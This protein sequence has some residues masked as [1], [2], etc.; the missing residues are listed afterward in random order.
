MKNNSFI[1]L[2]CILGI[3]L[4]SIMSYSVLKNLKEYERVQSIDVNSVKYEKLDELKKKILN[5]PY[6]KESKIEL[7]EERE[8]LTIDKS[9]ELTIKSNRYVMNIKDSK[10][11]NKYCELVDA[12]E[13]SLG[14]EVGKSLNTCKEALKGVIS[15]FGLNVD[16]GSDF[17]T[18]NLNNE[19]PI[20]L[21]DDTNS[22]KEK[23]LISIEEV[24]YNIKIDDYIFTSLSVNLDDKKLNV[25]SNIFN[26]KNKKEKTFVIKLFDKN[27][28]M[29]LEKEYN[30]L[31]DTS[32]YISFC[33]EFDISNEK[34]AYYSIEKK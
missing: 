20:T 21:Y 6:F 23:E 31:N 1:I 19:V 26:E 15:V 17:K 10:L 29:L 4:L 30:Y 13:M 24:N 2:M 12:I 28:E 34:P 7:D 9:L 18:I 5:S 25:C 32:K 11:E 3:L 16:F 8:K 27:K 33:I 14:L 22:H